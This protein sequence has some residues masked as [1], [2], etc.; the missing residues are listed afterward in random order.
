[1][2]A[3]KRNTG[4]IL[5]YRERNYE[6]SSGAPLAAVLYA[7]GSTIRGGEAVLLALPFSV[8]DLSGNLFY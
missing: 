4:N 7:L 5:L 8:L 6:I 2:V 3:H 1:M